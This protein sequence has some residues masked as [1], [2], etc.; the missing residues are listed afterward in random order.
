MENEFA[1][2]PTTEEKAPAPPTF[3]QMLDGLIYYDE[4]SDILPLAQYVRSR[5]KKGVDTPP[6]L[7][8]S[9]AVLLKVKP[10]TVQDILVAMLKRYMD[11]RPDEFLRVD[12]I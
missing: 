1:I 11:E 7:E 9:V 8:P 12:I 6:K 5:L 4:N 3:H 2:I 10:G